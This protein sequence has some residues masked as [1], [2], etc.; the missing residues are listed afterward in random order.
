MVK[1]ILEK[2]INSDR[3]KKF[4]NEV[5]AKQLVAQLKKNVK[6][7]KDKEMTLTK[8]HTEAKVVLEEIEKIGE[9]VKE[10]YAKDQSPYHSLFSRFIDLTKE[11]MYLSLRHY[12]LLNSP[13]RQSIYLDIFPHKYRDMNETQ[14][15][16]EL[17]KLEKEKAVIV[18][19]VSK[20]ILSG[21]DKK[22]LSREAE[23][24]LNSVDKLHFGISKDATSLNGVAFPCQF[25]SILCA[26]VIPVLCSYLVHAQVSEIIPD[27]VTGKNKTDKEIA[28]EVFTEMKKTNDV[29]S[30]RFSAEGFVKDLLGEEK[31]SHWDYDNPF[32]GADS[33]G[34][35]AKLTSA[36]RR[37]LPDS[38]F[39]LPER[40]EYPMPDRGHAIAAKARAKEML[41]KGYL[42]KKDYKKIIRKADEVL[43][44]E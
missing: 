19:E 36:Q 12:T 31:E 9:K 7:L 38:C 26:T 25:F 6:I 1:N 27:S 11:F 42:S 23:A 29:Y 39:G 28:K 17:N 4:V 22:K 35:E 41:E 24:Y 21:E 30:Y 13:D 3:E 43:G 14:I 10:Y 32:L 15:T 44:E 5:D 2:Q 16:D 37:A 8:D 20:R 18:R 40:R 34:L 33:V